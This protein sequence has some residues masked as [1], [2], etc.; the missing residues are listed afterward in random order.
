M[1]YQIEKQAENSQ[2][3][4]EYKDPGIRQTGGDAKK[5]QANS[6]KYGKFFGGKS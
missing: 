1:K 4:K 5:H 6:D 2:F 3:I